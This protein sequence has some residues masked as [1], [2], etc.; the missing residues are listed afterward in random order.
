MYEHQSCFYFANY[1]WE[2]TRN[3]HWEALS[4]HIPQF[5]L[6]VMPG[7]VIHHLCSSPK[8]PQTSTWQHPTPQ[9]LWGQLRSDYNKSLCPCDKG[10][11]SPVLE[12]AWCASLVPAL[13]HGREGGRMGELGVG[14]EPKPSPANDPR[15]SSVKDFGCWYAHTAWPTWASLL[16]CQRRTKTHFYSCPQ[17]TPTQTPEPAYTNPLFQS[18][19]GVQEILKADPHKSNGKASQPAPARVLEVGTD[20][21]SSHRRIP[22]RDSAGAVPRREQA[23]GAEHEQGRG[24]GRGGRGAMVCCLLL[25]REAVWFPGGGSQGAQLAGGGFKKSVRAC[26][27]K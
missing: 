11:T 24:G 4:P 5:L 26:F 25:G 2:S 18:P 27:K 1:S 17:L 23:A 3:R 9:P 20:K 14:R 21:I 15:E 12:G 22:C 13:T 16:R 7:A 10:H 8:W 6:S 19:S